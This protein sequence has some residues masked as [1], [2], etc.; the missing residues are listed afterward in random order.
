MASTMLATIVSAAPDQ[1]ERL[2]PDLQCMQAQFH[3]LA[4][5]EGTGGDWLSFLL[6]AHCSA[7]PGMEPAA[8]KSRATKDYYRW[9]C[10]QIQDP[11]PYPQELSPC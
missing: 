4:F 10:H 7:P 8:A 5:A 1:L 11:Q 2:S 6:L 9:R 3:R